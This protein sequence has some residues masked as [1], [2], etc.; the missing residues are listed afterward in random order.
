VLVAYGATVLVGTPG[1][2]ADVVARTRGNAAALDL[3]RLEVCSS[4]GPMAVLAVP[5]RTPTQAGRESWKTLYRAKFCCTE[6]LFCESIPRV[7]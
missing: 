4:R 3:R 6:S 1:R 5:T 2:L 7:E